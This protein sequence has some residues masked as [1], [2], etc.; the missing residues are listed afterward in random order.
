M[1]KSRNFAEKNSKKSREISLK[2]HQ[3]QNE[4]DKFQ[5]NKLQNPDI[6]R[7]NENIYKKMNMDRCEGM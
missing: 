3:N 6:L 2:F 5:K 7:K 1:P 4:N